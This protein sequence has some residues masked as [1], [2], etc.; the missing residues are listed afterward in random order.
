MATIN[1][2]LWL[3]NEK[4]TFGHFVEHQ[5][6]GLELFDW[7]V[8]TLGLGSRPAVIFDP[9]VDG[10][11]LR[12]YANG[13]S[14]MGEVR[15]YPLGAVREV[16]FRQA[17]EVI[18]LA[19]SEHLASPH[20]QIVPTWKKAP[21]HW[22]ASNA[23]A[24]I[25]SVI[26]VALKSTFVFCEVDKEGHVKTGRFD[27]SISYVD[28]S[29]RT[30]TYYGVLEL[31]VLKSAGSGGAIVAAADNLAAVKD[32]LVQA[33]SYRNDL[34]AFWA[35]LCC[36]DM[37]KDPDATD[38]C[39]AAIAGEAVQHDVN[40]SRWRLFNSVKKYRESISAS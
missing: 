26:K 14:D 25:Q 3:A 11:E 24:V 5:H 32:G 39:F 38:E 7:V 1:G 17:R 13:L 27:L 23:E 28:P 6:S 37:R 8:D 10:G 4:L 9:T 30:R 20:T 19:H 33:Y 29:T 2:R 35:A 21:T 31:K 22:A 18:D 12:Y 40:V 36:F 15:A 34:S 16:T